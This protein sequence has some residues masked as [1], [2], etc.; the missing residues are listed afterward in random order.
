MAGGTPPV[1]FVRIVKSS[2]D[3]I[4]PAGGGPPTIHLGAGTG[5]FV[6]LAVDVPVAVRDGGDA[7]GPPVATA[8]LSLTSAD[9]YLIEV[10]VRAA[11]G[12]RPWKLRITNNDDVEQLFT[13][14]VAD[15]EPES[16]QPWL[17]VPQSVVFEAVTGDTMTR[18]IPVGNRG[19]GVLTVSPGGLDAGPFELLETPEIAANDAGLLR[20]GFTAPDTP[21][22][23]D[24]TYV[25]R[26]NDVHA[27]ESPDHNH[28]VRLR[29]VT[30]KRPVPVPDD[31]PEPD[32]PVGGRCDICD[33]P[34]FQPR[35][36]GL[37]CR[38]TSCR[39]SFRVH[40]DPT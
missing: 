2:V 27:D 25:V 4:E 28:V 38:R 8:T 14:V 35:R 13:W 20:I 7:G 22:T 36:F 24:A 5:R 12:R 15:N 6:P 16:F 10:T 29:A 3:G 23:F 1:M 18:A 11:E 40:A 9:R 32:L 31:G 37:G 17:T 33:C 30:S 26:S 19:S 21:S 39:H 34:E